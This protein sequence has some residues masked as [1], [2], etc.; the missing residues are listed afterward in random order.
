M[1]AKQMQIEFER[2]IQLI[3]PDLVV[4]TKPNSDTIFSFLNAAQ[5][6]YVVLNYVGND[7]TVLETH[8]FN[9]NVDSIKSLVVE[10]TLVPAGI[11][12]LGFNKFALPTQYNKEYFLYIACSCLVTGTYKQ[13]SE[14]HVIASDLVKYEDLRNY[15]TTAFNSP[16]IRTPG[17]ALMSDPQSKLN[18][19]V[20]ATDK[21]TDLKSIILT[22]YRKPLRF[23][24]IGGQYVVDKCE[25]PESVHSEVVDM[26]VEMF[27]TEA[28]Y[29]LNVNQSAE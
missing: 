14:Q 21:Y 11:T 19:L 10:E 28:K 9:K 27:I 6:R 22:Y 20:I 12:A 23:N 17:A 2:R 3:S 5:D 1:S 29:R 25:L 24:T 15:E 4:D 16:I 7:Q 13:F 26:A 8:T 18:Y